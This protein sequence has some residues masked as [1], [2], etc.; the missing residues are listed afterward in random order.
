MKQAMHKG[1]SP[2]N[3]SADDARGVYLV[4]M[5]IVSLLSVSRH[6]WFARVCCGH[7]PA[8]CIRFWKNS[9]AESGNACGW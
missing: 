2:R 8:L 6:D 7:L 5:G 9:V 4:A 1:C 3:R